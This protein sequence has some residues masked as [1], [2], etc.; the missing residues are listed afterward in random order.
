MLEI[1]FKT[2]ILSE[3]IFFRKDTLTAGDIIH[4]SSCRI[5]FNFTQ[6][7][8]NTAA[9]SASNRHELSKQTGATEEGS[10]F[11]LRNTEASTTDRISYAP[12]TGCWA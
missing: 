3:Q 11:S 8:C 12:V 1:V 10:S 4:T 7:E 2:T 9:S 5:D 6:R